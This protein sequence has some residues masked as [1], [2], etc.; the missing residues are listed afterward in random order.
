MLVLNI[1]ESQIYKFKL[2]F[3]YH[4]LHF[5]DIFI[6]LTSDDIKF[7]FKNSITEY[8]KIFGKYE[9][10]NLTLSDIQKIKNIDYDGFYHI[11]RL[12]INF[13]KNKNYQLK[14]FFKVFYLGMHL[15]HFRK[16][17]LF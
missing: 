16:R 2:R 1:L 4:W 10:Y 14:D 7:C 11:K 3:C 12:F 13:I 17:R 9:N 6:T 8:E 5:K 15:N